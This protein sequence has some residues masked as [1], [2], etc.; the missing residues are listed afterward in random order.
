MVYFMYVDRRRQ[1]GGGRFRSVWAVPRRENSHQ[2]LRKYLSRMSL[3]P[4]GI[5]LDLE[6]AIRDIG[7]RNNL[8]VVERTKKQ[9]KYPHPTRPPSRIPQMVNRI[10]PPPYFFVIFPPPY[11]F[12]FWPTV[13][14][15][16]PSSGYT[17]NPMQGNGL[18]GRKIGIQTISN[19]KRPGPDW[20]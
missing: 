3:G 19:S 4:L 6:T 8:S 14:H 10:F 1:C 12:H 18:H 13:P 5:L 15:F 2:R 11:F 16:V 17:G 7:F 9:I 20:N